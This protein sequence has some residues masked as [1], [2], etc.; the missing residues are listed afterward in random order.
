MQGKGAE[1][2]EA[3]GQAIEVHWLLLALPFCMQ[4][5]PPDNTSQS[6]PCVLCDTCVVLFTTCVVPVSCLYCTQIVCVFV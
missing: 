5:R 4:I 2:A 6:Y 3:Y 1:A